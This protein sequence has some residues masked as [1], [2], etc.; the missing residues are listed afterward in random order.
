M[1]HHTSVV[2]V[3]TVQRASAIVDPGAFGS[4]ALPTPQVQS[5]PR[6]Q[7]LLSVTEDLAGALTPCEV[8]TVIAAR[9]TRALGASSAVVMLLDEETGGLDCIAS[10]DVASDELVAWRNLP[11]GRPCPLTDAMRSGDAVA[12]NSAAELSGRYPRSDILGP[13]GGRV[14]VPLVVRGRSVGGICFQYSGDVVLAAED[15]AFAFALAKQCSLALERGMFFRREEQQR[16]NVGRLQQI[17]AALART[18]T[19]EEATRA[20]VEAVAEGLHCAAGWLAV[21]APEGDDVCMCYARGTGQDVVARPQRFPLDRPGP[22]RDV[23]VSGEMRCFRDAASYAAAYAD[24]AA[25]TGEDGCEGA[26]LLPLLI[27]GTPRAVLGLRFAG[28]VRFDDDFLALLSAVEVECAAALQRAQLLD[29]ERAARGDLAF[30]LEASELLSSSLDGEHTLQTLAD[31]VVPRVADWCAVIVVGADGPELHGFAHRQESKR[32]FGRELRRR[33]LQNPSL[34][35]G[36]TEVL[37]TGKARILPNISAANIRRRLVDPFFAEPIDELGLCSLMIVPLKHDDDVLGALVLG[38]GDGERRFGAQAVALAEEIAARASTAMVHT[39]QHE[40]VRRARADAE[41]ARTEAERAREQAE[42]ASRVKDEFLALLGHELRNPLMPITTALALMKLR[43]DDAH[44]RERAIIERQANHLL[45]LVDDLLDVS[46]IARGKIELRRRAIE[47]APIISRAVEIVSPALEL[48]AHR[49][50]IDVP[51]EGVRVDGDEDRLVQV[52]S[53][54][55]SNAARYTPRG[56]RISLS[57]QA[58]GGHVVVRV[59]DNGR[60]MS[61]EL[62][63]HVFDIFRQGPRTI[64]R[65]EG[66]LGL[67]LA[68][69]KNF[70]EFHGGQVGASSEGPGRGSEFWVRLPLLDSREVTPSVLHP[71]LRDMAPAV[72]GRRVLV[73]DDNADAA[74]ALAEVLTHVGHDVAIA[75]DGP[76]ALALAAQRA[77]EVALLDIGL[78]V[79]DGYELASRLRELVGDDLMLVAI[80]GYGQESD[81]ERARRAGF[82]HHRVKPVA[83]PELLTLVDKGGGG[84]HAPDRAA[85]ADPTAD[86]GASGDGASD[87]RP[88]EGDHAGARRGGLS[89]GT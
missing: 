43:D 82:D 44:A 84:C 34:P 32:S 38:L 25:Q 46:R 11:L 83:V 77:P 36:L 27:D 57:A 71:D 18:M 40:E 63:P 88:P 6:L 76:S 56:G 72:R 13:P 4:R 7:A 48:G 41:R 62:L 70:V 8:A 33:R 61:Q 3:R 14:A 79:M 52:F 81:R 35:D 20:I 73:V 65:S 15:L 31:L 89:A 1:L 64:D 53:N 55:L 5:T 10:Q 12:A 22:V 2:Q 29:A 51:A 30:L 54:L 26:V 28:V 60:G 49:L 59:R 19:M 16:A 69:V 58:S 68:I 39:R 85:A 67:G 47:L 24:L 9:G 23:L 17:T 42:G 86:D 87:E 74:H 75:H 66:G 21:V 50:D 78:P 80:T 37:T 45:R